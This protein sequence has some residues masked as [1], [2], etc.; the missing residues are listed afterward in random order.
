MKILRNF[1]TYLWFNLYFMARC[2]RLKMLKRFRFG[3]QDS[4]TNPNPNIICLAKI[5]NPNPNIRD[6]EEKIRIRIRIFVTTLI[7]RPSWYIF[8]VWVN[9]CIYLFKNCL[10]IL[11]QR[12]FGKYLVNLNR[13]ISLKG[14]QEKLVF[15]KSFPVNLYSSQF[16]K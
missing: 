5:T 1:L 14:N 2:W 12:K 13:N 4:V 16:E 10:N 9:L 7:F 11:V 8:R 3:G 15:Y 6:S